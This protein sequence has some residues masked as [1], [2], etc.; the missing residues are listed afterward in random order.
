MIFMFSGCNKGPI[1]RENVKINMPADNTVNGYLL[2]GKSTETNGTM[3][4][5]ISAPEVGITNETPQATNK[6][7]DYC[8]NKNSKVFHLSSCSSVNKMKD[9]N[10]VHLKNRQ[11]FINQ[12]YKPCSI[13]TP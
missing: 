2:Q 13:C 3:P 8:G 12:S 4:D 11:E 1:E 9:E 7:T 10:K 6:S 5:I